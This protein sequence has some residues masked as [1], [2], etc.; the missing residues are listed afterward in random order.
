MAVH[1]AA[2]VTHLPGVTCDK[3]C[4]VI[5][6]CGVILVFGLLTG[7]GRSAEHLKT[8]IVLAKHYPSSAPTHV[9][10]FVQQQTAYIPEYQS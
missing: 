10:L 8:Y 4:C 6:E 7:R 3:G 2:I 9:R 1:M 5:P